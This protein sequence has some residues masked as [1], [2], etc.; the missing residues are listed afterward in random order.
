MSFSHLSSR[1]LSS[2][3]RQR[4]NFS[5]PSGLCPCFR[6][7]CRDSVAPFVL[8]P[9]WIPPM[10]L[11][12][13]T[14]HLLQCFSSVLYSAHFLAYFKA[15]SSAASL[16]RFLWT[17]QAVKYIP[18]CAAT[19]PCLYFQPTIYL[20]LLQLF[21]YMFCSLKFDSWKAGTLFYWFFHPQWLGRVATYRFCEHPSSHIDTTKEIGKKKICSPCDKNSQDLLS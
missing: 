8:Q 14:F 5:A 16:R 11:S 9:C 13:F 3:T 15:S 6:L 4:W 17:L 19:L 18:L 10:I 12:I 7:I 1:V 20:T 21:I 2:F